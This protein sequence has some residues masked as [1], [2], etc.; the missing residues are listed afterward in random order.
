MS[1]KEC[2]RYQNEGM[3]AYFF[4]FGIADIAIVACPKHAGEVMAV[5]REHQADD[6]RIKETKP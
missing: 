2:E 1:C 6:S 3:G 5:L 4:R